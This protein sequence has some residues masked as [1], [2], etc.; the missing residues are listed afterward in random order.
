M[1]YENYHSFFDYRNALTQRQP[2]FLDAE[3]AVHG[4]EPFLVKIQAVDIPDHGPALLVRDRRASFAGKFL[5]STI[6]DD[7]HLVELL[8]THFDVIYALATYLGHQTLRIRID[9]IPDQ[10]ML[11][12]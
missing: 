12:W 7:A 1:K 3:P 8:R 4:N 11:I 2:S 5:L 9:P 6:T 10:S